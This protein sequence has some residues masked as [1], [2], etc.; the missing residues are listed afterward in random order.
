MSCEEVAERLPDEDPE[1]AEH[2]RGCAA[3]RA[4]HEAY[5]RDA[6]RLAAGLRAE[7]GDSALGAPVAARLSERPAPPRRIVP[8][9]AA[10]AML[11]G[12]LAVLFAPER[13]ID[14][15]KG[16]SAA[17]GKLDKPS[18]LVIHGD[19]EGDLQ[20]IPTDHVIWAQ[21]MGIDGNRMVT[22][23]A[24]KAD[25]IEIDHQLTLYRRIQGGYAEIGTLRVLEVEESTSSGRVVAATDAPRVGDIVVSGQ[26]LSADEKQALLEYVFSFRLRREEGSHPYDRLVRGAGL[27]RDVE[28]LARLKDPR[29]YDRLARIL[30]NVAPFAKDGFPL[31]GPDLAPQMHAWWA[32]AKDRVRWNAAADRYEE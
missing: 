4:L 17:P 11:A 21:V 20:M 28:F 29:A 8:L 6:E 30:E 10:A 18:L 12:V 32:G 25:A 13:G 7:A 9:A 22:V 2:L 27:E 16:G 31:A 14:P 24:G 1:I 26:P 5:E 15:V 23:T 3:C 19:E